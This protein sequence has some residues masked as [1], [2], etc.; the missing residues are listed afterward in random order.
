VNTCGGGGSVF[1]RNNI[2]LYIFIIPFI[3][4]TGG[5]GKRLIRPVY[6]HSRLGLGVF[7]NSLLEEVS[8]TL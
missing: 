3:L 2:E 4:E 1:L 8:F 7:P 5:E 6:A